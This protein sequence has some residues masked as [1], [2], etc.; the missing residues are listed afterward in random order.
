[1]E[2]K[3]FL[4]ILLHNTKRT[5]VSILKY[6]FYSQNLAH[7]FEKIFGNSCMDMANVSWKFLTNSNAPIPL[8]F[9]NIL[10]V[11]NILVPFVSSFFL[12]CKIKLDLRADCTDFTGEL[13]LHLFYCLFIGEGLIEKKTYYILHNAITSF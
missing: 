11:L 1:M 3:T 7:D 6:C 2:K 12:R 4:D 9:V 10:F 5:F 13:F 8:Y